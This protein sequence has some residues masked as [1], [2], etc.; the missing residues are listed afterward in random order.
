MVYDVTLTDKA[1]R[2]I[3]DALKYYCNISEILHQRFKTVIIGTIDRLKSTP[4][5]HQ[6]R[7][8]GIRIAH[9]NKFPYGVHFIIEG[10]TVRILRVLHHSQFYK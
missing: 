9:T 5:H 8:R 4:K 7:Y 10:N 3:A 2:D 6:I 1:I